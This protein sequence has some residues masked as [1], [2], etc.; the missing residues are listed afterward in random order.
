MLPCMKHRYLLLTVFTS[1]F[2]GE[3]YARS[4]AGRDD[5]GASA[6]MCDLIWYAVESYNGLR[7]YMLVAPV[8]DDPGMQSFTIVTLRYSEIVSCPLPSARIQMAKDK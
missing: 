2:L 1:C 6:G 5:P 7:R 4:C 3:C 8:R